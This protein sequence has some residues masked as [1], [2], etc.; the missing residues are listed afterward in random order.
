MGLEVTTDGQ[1]SIKES[2]YRRSNVQGKQK[3]VDGPSE[4]YGRNVPICPTLS[5]L[6]VACGN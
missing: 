6:D 5:G 4:K 1:S 3:M 2:R